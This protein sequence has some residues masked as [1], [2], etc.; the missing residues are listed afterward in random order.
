MSTDP[1]D[2]LIVGAGPIGLLLAGDLAASG[3]AT[4]VLERRAQQSNLSRAFAVH[5][6]TL[7]LLD[8]RGLADELVT[9]GQTVDSLRLFERTAVDMTRL[10]TR[11]PHLLITP[12]YNLERLLHR[13]ARS[14]GATFR[15]GTEVTTMDQ[16][17][18][19]VRVQARDSDGQEHTYT[20][21]YLVG[22]DG[23]RSTVRRTLGL[24]FPG[25]SVMRSVMLADVRLA[26]PP[27][28]VLAVNGV[29]AGFAFVAPFG[30]GWY[31]I[32]AWN[33]HRQVADSEPV[34]LD[35][36]REITRQA[37]GSDYGMRDARWTSRFHND[38]RQV[39]RYRVGRVLLAGDAAHVHSPAGG[40]G[41]N[42][43]LQDVANLSW[44][45]AAVVR[46]RAEDTLLDS[47][48]AERY[49]VDR[50]ALRTS[51]RI[52]R[53][54]LLRHQ[55]VRTAR[56]LAGSLISRIRPANTAIARRIS[57]IGIAYP[58]ARG[59]HPLAGRR[60]PDIRLIP[61]QHHDST[62]LYEALRT[63]RFVLL[64]A[65]RPAPLVDWSDQVD[66]AVPATGRQRT[67]L[68]RPDGYIAWATDER[69]PSRRDGALRAALIRW[70][71]A[72]D[73]R[74]Q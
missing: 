35:E 56:N 39:P 52:L 74:D 58:A 60:A 46:G 69:N 24:P 36:V 25:K 38:E 4:T 65:E 17:H 62:R 16:D 9:T 67:I 12:Q 37:L 34:D 13:R 11:F 71:G 64:A 10:P 6:R 45:V 33:R 15:T 7:E 18:D 43:G 14:L 49:P 68:V 61:D 47:Y 23:V 27:E 40:L 29:A 59:A 70:C 51:A 41:L 26:D 5:A 31:R 22:A 2:V 21:R 63:Q 66:H 50:G 57:G 42:T 54:A 73:E 44:K 20:A 72:P 3:V 8:A 53:L 19:G 55:T 1:C 28:Q 32:I 48:Q 30:D